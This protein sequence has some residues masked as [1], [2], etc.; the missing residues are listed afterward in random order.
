VDFNLAQQAPAYGNRARFRKTYPHPN[1]HEAPGHAVEP[2]GYPDRTGLGAVPSINH[3]TVS[4]DEVQST[5]DASDSVRQDTSRQSSE[6]EGHPLRLVVM[7][8][9]TELHPVNL[10][11]VGTPSLH[12]WRKI[13]SLIMSAL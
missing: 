2:I 12:R 5:T 3:R 13:A 1:P 10:L 9:S 8:T 6:C 11:A 4:D 7:R